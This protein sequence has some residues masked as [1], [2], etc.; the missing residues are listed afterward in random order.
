LDGSILAPPANPPGSGTTIDNR[1]KSVWGAA[2][3]GQ[4][5]RAKVETSGKRS[6]RCPSDE[7]AH[8]APDGAERCSEVFGQGPAATSATVCSVFSILQ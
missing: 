1:H 3:L 6:K 4:R 8:P 5:N 2:R 7:A